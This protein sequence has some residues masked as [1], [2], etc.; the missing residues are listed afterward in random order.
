MMMPE[1]FS[2]FRNEGVLQKDIHCYI[3]LR[4]RTLAKEISFEIGFIPKE[5]R[6]P[7]GIQG[8]NKKSL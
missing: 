3:V 2:S 1:Q 5:R 7:E 6:G 8:T 4:K